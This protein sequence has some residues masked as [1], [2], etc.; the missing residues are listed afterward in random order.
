MSAVARYLYLF[1][2]RILAILAAK[3]LS[4]LNVA[5]A[6]LVL[7]LLNCIRHETS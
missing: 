3:I 5:G 2:T 7:A 6:G 4:S 1:V